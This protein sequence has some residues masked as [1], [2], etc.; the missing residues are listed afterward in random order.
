MT[1]KQ[2]N[3]NARETRFPGGEAMREVL[4]KMIHAKSRNWNNEYIQIGNGV[5]DKRMMATPRQSVNLKR[6]LIRP[7]VL[8]ASKIPVIIK[9]VPD[10]RE[11]PLATWKESQFMASSLWPVRLSCERIPWRCHYGA[12]FLPW[13]KHIRVDRRGSA[14]NIAPQRGF[15]EFVVVGYTHGAP[16]EL[17]TEISLILRRIASDHQVRGD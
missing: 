10:I 7:L 17:W 4:S 16:M 8:A 3:N 15:W 11:A 12:A 13:N 5:E 9:P 6:N 14:V 2:T 1:R